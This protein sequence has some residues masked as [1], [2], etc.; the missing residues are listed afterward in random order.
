MCPHASFLSKAVYDSHINLVTKEASSSV[1][2]NACYDHIHEMILDD[3]VFE[4]HVKVE[5]VVRFSCWI[6]DCFIEMTP[7]EAH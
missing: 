3:V 7:V 1:S 6:L 2:G 4:L 5:M